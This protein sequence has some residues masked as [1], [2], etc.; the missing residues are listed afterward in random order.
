MQLKINKWN[1]VIVEW[2]PYSQFDSIKEM[3]NINSTTLY[4]AIW[5]DGPLQVDKYCGILK[6]KSNKNVTLKSLHNLPNIANKSL[7]EV[8]VFLKIN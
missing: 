4:S 3:G 5:K 6:R 1:D 2:I 8:N 7:N